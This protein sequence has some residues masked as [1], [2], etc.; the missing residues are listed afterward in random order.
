MFDIHSRES[1]DETTKRFDW[2][3]SEKY[4]LKENHQIVLIGM[5]A[6]LESMRQVSA[7]EAESYATANGWRYYESSNVEGS[8]NSA[9]T[10]LQ[11]TLERHMANQRCGV[12]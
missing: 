10:I 3:T 9:E 1:Y 7:S 2:N 4:R 6:D 11:E 8:L 5:K 12:V